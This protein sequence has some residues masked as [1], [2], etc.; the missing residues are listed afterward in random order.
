MSYWFSDHYIPRPGLSAAHIQD[1]CKHPRV[2]GTGA[3]YRFTVTVTAFPVW[4]TTNAPKLNQAWPVKPWQGRQPFRT[5]KAI[6]CHAGDLHLTLRAQRANTG[7]W[8]TE[9]IFR[10]VGAVA[11]LDDWE[12]IA[13]MRGI[14]VAAF[15]ASAQDPDLVYAA[16][17]GHGVYRS[18]D[19]GL[20]WTKVST[21]LRGLHEPAAVEV[22][23]ADDQVIWTD[24]AVSR[25]GGQT[26][27]R[28]AVRDSVRLVTHPGDA[29]VVFACRGEL[30]R[31]D[32]YGQVSA[33]LGGPE[34]WDGMGCNDVIVF[35]YDINWM[36][37]GTNDGL[38]E[39]V[40]A[41]D[42]WQQAH[43]GLPPVGINRIF[44]GDTRVVLA[45]QGRGVQSVSRPEVEA[46]RT[47][48]AL[49]PEVHQEPFRLHANYPNPFR[50]ST[51]FDVQLNRP[52]RIRLEVYDLTGRQVSVL[53]DRAY[54]AGTHRVQWQ[55][56]GRASGVYFVRLTADDRQISTRRLIL[57]R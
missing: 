55:A 26:W 7:S 9:S 32:N 20:T 40:D 42:T 56:G 4:R 34:D 19:F 43:R 33:L 18:P 51:S 8:G 31:H 17:P 46:L 27:Q 24:M 6:L 13:T 48:I 39:T 35:P 3:D 12:E 22:A 16:S 49:A 1:V 36:W 50:A 23:K 25:D 38:W 52:A 11:G 44:L 30:T 28:W 41:G 47:G 10:S 57:A 54:A 2:P 29:S 15:S 45:T 53:T 21:V 5:Q 14:E 37:V